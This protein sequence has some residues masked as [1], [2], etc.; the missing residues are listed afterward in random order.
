MSE[1]KGLNVSVKS[2]LGAILVILVLMIGT[3]LL[4][5]VIPAGE[6]ARIID[7]AG[8]TVI[9]STGSFRYTQGSLTFGKFLLSPILVLGAEG[10]GTII[11]I[12]I[13]LLVIGGEKRGIS[14]AVLSEADLRVRIGYHGNFRGSLS[15]AASAAVATPLPPLNLN[16]MGHR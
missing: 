10:G 5:F 8:N 11:A 7:E 13:F 16:Q 3:Y 2:F 12:I 14:R 9:V 15:S 4:T 6:Y 1:N